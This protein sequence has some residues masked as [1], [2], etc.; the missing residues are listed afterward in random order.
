MFPRFA[1]RTDAGRALADRLASA[2]A[3]GTVVL[4]LP[5]GGVV[6]AVEVAT[7][8]RAPLDVLPVRKLGLPGHPELAMGAIAALGDT[9]ETVRIDDVLTRARVPA[10]AFDQV[11]TAELRELR[12]REAAYRAGRPPLDVR[13]R[14][15]LVVDDGLAT[16][17]TMRAAVAAVRRGG[18]ARVAVAVPVGASGACADLSRE[19]DEVVCLATPEPFRAVASGYDAFGDT[20]DDEVRAA[21]RREA[22]PP[23]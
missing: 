23:A 16:G 20:D 9:L 19:A 7:G 11:R 17:A 22:G 12:R 6:V 21:L 14:P 1:D 2:A 3:P 4:G 15:V 10:D 13:A 5:R 18:A 8:L